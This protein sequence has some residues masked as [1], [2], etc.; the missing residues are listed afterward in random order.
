METIN[1]VSHIKIQIED[2]SY[3][4]LLTPKLDSLKS[5]FDQEIINEIVLWKVNRYAQIKPEALDLLNELCTSLSVFHFN[6]FTA[7]CNCR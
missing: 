6:A 5:D 7:N 1:S 4:D 2:Y 3:Q